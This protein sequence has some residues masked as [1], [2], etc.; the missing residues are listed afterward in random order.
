MEQ[1]NHYSNIPAKTAITAC[2]AIGLFG[3]YQFSL[4]SS[5]A[6]MADNIEDSLHLTSVDVSF[7]VASYLIAF[8]FSQVFWGLL[9]DR[10]GAALVVPMTTLCLG[11]AVF[12]FS[13][14]D[15]FT[16]VALSRAGMGLCA[17]VIMPSFAGVARKCFSMRG[18]SLALSICVSIVTM[19]GIV[20]NYA[21]YI[22][23]D[24]YGW[25]DTYS[26]A[27][28]ISIPV[29]V[30]ALFAIRYRNF[31]AI[32][33]VQLK[34]SIATFQTVSLPLRKLIFLPGVARAC[35]IHTA[36]S[37]ILFNFGSFWNIQIA[38]AWNIPES[39]CAFIGSAFYLGFAIGTPLFGWWAVHVGPRK[40]MIVSCVVGIAALLFWILIP[41]VWPL[42]CD[43]L[44]V[45]LIGLAISS[46]PISFIIASQFAPPR[47]AASVIGLVNF[48]GI[49]AGTLFGMIPSLF[50]QIRSISE[51][52]QIQFGTIIFV[53]VLVV[54][55]VAAVG[56]PKRNTT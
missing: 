6:T 17:A 38:L 15:S 12:F 55:L 10:F 48:V 23:G 54:A 42:W 28:L 34:E 7:I 24:L 56:I 33:A 4:Q 53:V 35:V 30:F 9:V 14:S 5:F 21:G 46:Y 19:G 47:N 41:I 13:R 40:P 32:R 36:T 29:A 51:L 44:N 50:T 45:F 43:A 20:G 11:A 52:A 49:I 18:F 31:P 22:L 1:T 25:R 37:G 16:Q 26:Y 3:V 2:V 39:D 8:G 27:A